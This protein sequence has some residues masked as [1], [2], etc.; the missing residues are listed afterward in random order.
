MSAAVLLH[1]SFIVM[2]GAS[3]LT[4]QG[5]LLFRA[6]ARHADA[7]RDDPRPPVETSERP[8]GDSR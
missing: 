7:A 3:I 5:D 8:T 6:G 2:P 4:E 1:L